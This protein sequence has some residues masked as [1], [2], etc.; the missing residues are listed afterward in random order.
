[1]GSIA[2]K[3]MFG[4]QDS[5]VIISGFHRGDDEVSSRRQTERTFHLFRSILISQAGSAGSMHG[6]RRSRHQ[7]PCDL[8][9]RHDRF[10]RVLACEV[11]R[12]PHANAI[13][14]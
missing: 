11:W 7:I 5:S 12:P 3:L 1:M 9:F 6:E 8:S 2:Q 4:T 14:C 10:V 13:R